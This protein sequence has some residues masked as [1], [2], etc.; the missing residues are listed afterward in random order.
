MIDFLFL[1]NNISRQKYN[2][3]K[4]INYFINKRRED[5]NIEIQIFK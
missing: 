4:N 1:I 5:Q 2:F 3:K